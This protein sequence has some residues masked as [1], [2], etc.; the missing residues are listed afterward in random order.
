M[1][2]DLF[3]EG[4]YERRRTRLTMLLVSVGI[5]V[6][7]AGA[8]AI[9]VGLAVFGGDNDKSASDARPKSTTSA[10]AISSATPSQVASASPV[11]PPATYISAPRS[12][13]P[14]SVVGNPAISWERLCERARL[15]RAAAKQQGMGDCHCQVVALLHN[16]KWGFSLENKQWSQTI[17]SG[18][19]GVMIQTP[20]DL[21]RGLAGLTAALRRDNGIQITA[22]VDLYSGSSPEIIEWWHSADTGSVEFPKRYA[23]SDAPLAGAEA[24]LRS[25]LKVIQADWVK[26]ADY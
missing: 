4:E 19:G 5:T 12:E 15:I 2:S 18:E 24:S 3:D 10:A 13:P 17:P 11:R 25:R 22:I 9:V 8:A 14:R 6:A 23:A 20:Y 21:A 16:G 26:A 1:S 7:F